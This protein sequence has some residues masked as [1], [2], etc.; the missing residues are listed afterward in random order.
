[1][2]NTDIP[3]VDEEAVG[4]SD[5]ILHTCTCSMQVEGLRRVSSDDDKVWC[6]RGLAGGANSRVAAAGE[7]RGV[8]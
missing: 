3:A 7:G 2:A 4:G 1:M 5:G 8:L 6:S